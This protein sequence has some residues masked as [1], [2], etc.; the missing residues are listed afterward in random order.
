VGRNLLRRDLEG[1][2]QV[3][4]ALTVA[5]VG[6]AL[7]LVPRDPRLGP[8]PSRDRPRG[9]VT[10][11]GARLSHHR[12]LAAARRAR[13]CRGPWPATRGMAG[14][15]PLHLD[16]PWAENAIGAAAPDIRCNVVRGRTGRPR[17]L[18][19]A[20]ARN[21]SVMGTVRSSSSRPRTR[22]PRSRSRPTYFDVTHRRSG[23]AGTGRSQTAPPAIEQRAEDV[24][25]P[26]RKSAQVLVRRSRPTPPG[27]PARPPRPAA[28]SGPRFAGAPRAG[29]RSRNAPS[30]RNSGRTALR[31]SGVRRGRRRPPPISLKRSVELAGLFGFGVADG[32]CLASPAIRLLGSRRRTLF[33]S[34]TPEDLNSSPFGPVAHVGATRCFRTPLTLRRT[35]TRLPRN[36][37]HPA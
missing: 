7:A 4:P 15:G 8:Y 10:G 19:A 3:G 28:R 27:T 21:S 22:S 18:P 11:R 30:R 37:Y 26:G 13:A 23:P 31:L 20:G 14:Q 12:P 35:A 2:D 29:D 34:R 36:R 16:P 9:R 6:R 33:R 32:V 25:E 5:R 17:H 24:P 1:V